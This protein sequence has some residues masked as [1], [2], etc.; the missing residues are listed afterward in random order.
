V[1]WL[2]RGRRKTEQTGPGRAGEREG[3]EKGRLGWPRGRKRKE[4]KEDGPGQWRKKRE[5]HK[6]IQLHLNLNLK[7]KFKWKTS[8]KIMQCGMKC[9]RPTFYYISF[10]G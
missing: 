9:T 2:A 3:K 1:G 5:K 4:E 7:F 6:C 10:Y 8:N